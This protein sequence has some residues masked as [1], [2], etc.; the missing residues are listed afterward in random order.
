[1][2]QAETTP[3]VENSPPPPVCDRANADGSKCS[4][5][6]QFTY[7]WE[8]GEK[9]VCCAQHQFLQTQIASQIGR[10]VQFTP[11]VAAGPVAMTRDER[12]RLKGEVYALEE[13]LKDVQARGLALYRENELLARQ[14]QAATVRGRETELQLK[15]ALA[16]LDRARKDLE[17]RDAEHGNLVDEV[18]R[19]RT[20]ASFIDDTEPSRVDGL[21]PR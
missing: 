15:E 14:A 21:T 19:L 2:P 18:G 9:G 5:P 4:E 7:F 8:W 17:A 10:N 6:A 20:L 1:M 11:I 16:D 12:T 13:E 3:V